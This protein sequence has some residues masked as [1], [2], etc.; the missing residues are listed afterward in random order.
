MENYLILLI[1]IPV[2]WYVGMIG[3]QLIKLIGLWL[4]YKLSNIITRLV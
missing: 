1:G 2:V 4:Q 3:Y